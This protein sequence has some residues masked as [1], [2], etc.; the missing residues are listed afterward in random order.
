MNVLF[1]APFDLTIRDGT[2]IRVTNITKA[3]SLFCRN[4]LLFS[5]TINE[6]LSILSNLKYVALKPTQF[7][8]NL[9]ASLLGRINPLLSYKFVS[10]L[11][12]LNVDALRDVIKYIDLMHVHF[13]EFGYIAKIIRFSL[14]KDVPIIIDLHGLYKL[15]ILPKYSIR[16]TIGHML[17]LIHEALTIRDS[18]ID[19]LTVPSKGIKIL[20]TRMYNIDSSKIF[21]IP[22]VVDTATIETARRC[23]DTKT[24]IIE[25][26]TKRY[27]KL[28]GIVAYTGTISTY[29]G[30]FD[31]VEAIKIARRI[32]N[33]NFKLLLIVPDM[34]QLIQFRN[35]LPEDTVILEKIPRRFIPCILRGASVLV[36]P[37]RA[38]TQFDYIPSNKV[39]DYILAGRPIVAYR[40][41]AVA[42]AL[43]KYPMHILVEPNNPL[44]LAK[45]II[46]ALE[47]YS[48]VEPKPAYDKVPT[49]EVVESSL[50]R[51]YSIVLKQYK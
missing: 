10:K 38:G 13:L 37:H 42:E 1:V 19:A 6:E 39:Y 41:P 49:L 26:L 25:R 47:L 24:W 36:L 34:N 35:L 18:S 23:N 2:S 50:K 3:A 8:Y 16:N 27:A 30:F 29:H 5:N 21:V 40:T 32:S 48:N 9:I 20:L 4:I 44:A 12:D 43:N 51:I 46:K 17:A 7:R 14:N 28:N 11:S 45:G 33:R 31:L 15:Q 22:D